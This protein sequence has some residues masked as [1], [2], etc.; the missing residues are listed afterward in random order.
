M[1]KRERGDST[2]PRKEKSAEAVS[3][4]KKSYAL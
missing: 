4:K 3:Q 2:M 1:K